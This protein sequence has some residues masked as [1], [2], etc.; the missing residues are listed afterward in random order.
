MI[1]QAFGNSGAVAHA[2]NVSYVNIGPDGT[3]GATGS[4]GSTE[5][6]RESPGHSLS[7]LGEASQHGIMMLYY[8]L[9]T[10]AQCLLATG[11]VCD[12]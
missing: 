9:L 7:N 3:A 11:I 8:V 10:I 12:G 5:G 1:S 6:L 4:L 2:A